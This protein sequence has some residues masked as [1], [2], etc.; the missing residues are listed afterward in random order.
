MRKRSNLLLA[1][2]SLFGGILPLIL[3]MSLTSSSM[4]MSPLTSAALSMYSGIATALAAVWILPKAATNSP[5][6]SKFKPSL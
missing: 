3:T 2:A 1:S 6:A 4:A 5:W